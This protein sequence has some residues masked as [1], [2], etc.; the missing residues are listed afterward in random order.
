MR[1]LLTGASSFTGAWFA[2]AL[3]AAGI[4]VTATCRGRLDRYE[5]LA[6]R[7]LDAVRRICRLVDGFADGA[8]AFAEPVDL[9]CLHGATVGDHRAAGFDP[10]AALAA[11]TAGLEPLLDRFLAQGGRAVL[12]TGSIFEA[13]VGQGTPPH[14]ALSPYGLAKTLTFQV[15]RH[16]VERRRLT[17][18]RFVIPHPFGPLEKPGLTAAL[19][20]AW[21]L[22][23]VP[24]IR[25]P[26]LV[27]DFVPID[28]LAAAYARFAG[29]L[30][31]ADHPLTLTPS[32]WP[33]STAVFVARFG[34][35]LGPR[36]GLP[37]RSL[38]AEPPEPSAEP[39]IR[40]GTDALGTWLPHWDESR[41]WNLVARWHAGEDCPW[42]DT[43]N[44]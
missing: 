5:G 39:L 24:L 40:V 35:E 21:H 22:G 10:L 33:E 26:H 28:A 1:A 4:E 25:Q 19:A 36:L 38:S 7:R 42:G 15:I 18:G 32:F 29:A 9:L 3:T 17:L 20:Q 14:G 43:I 8:G 12:A 27:R 11:D 30:L 41:S 31:V 23:E 2:H 34:R 6:R 44:G 16:Q 37:C 13:D